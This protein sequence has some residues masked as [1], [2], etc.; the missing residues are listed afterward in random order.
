MICWSGEVLQVACFSFRKWRPKIS[1]HGRFASSI[2]PP[3]DAVRLPDVSLNCGAGDVCSRP[4]A[5]EPVLA[6][7]NW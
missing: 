7:A 1:G 5:H 3:A 6:C 2:I 4:A